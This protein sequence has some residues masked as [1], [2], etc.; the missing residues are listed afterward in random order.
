MTVF[1]LGCS[2]HSYTLYVFVP[3]C[4]FE[5][6]K[7]YVCVHLSMNY[8]AQR[9]RSSDRGRP[10]RGWVLGCYWYLLPWKKIPSASELCRSTS[11]G[12]DSGRKSTAQWVVAYRQ[13][14]KY[15][16]AR[17]DFVTQW[18]F[19]NQNG[20]AHSNPQRTIG[21]YAR[22]RMRRWGTQL[23]HVIMRGANK[24]EMCTTWLQ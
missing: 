8:W 10:H 19:C 11:C 15:R 1:C 22:Q 24:L 14:V 9:K 3:L 5:S 21:K 17:V 16:N 12:S 18:G 20:G 4:Q 13:Q 7:M 6:V 2:L 23:C